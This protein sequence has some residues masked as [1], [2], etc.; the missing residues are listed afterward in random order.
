MTQL[1]ANES[2]STKFLDIYNERKLGQETAKQPN[3]EYF[4]NG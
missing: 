2:F 1:A 3:L 4:L